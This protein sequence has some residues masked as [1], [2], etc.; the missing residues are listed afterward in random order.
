MAKRDYSSLR[1]ELLIFE[2]TYMCSLCV[3]KFSNPVRIKVC[4]HYFC[5]NC[6]QQ[7]NAKKGQCPKCKLPYAND[8][9]DFQNTARKVTEYLEKLE[10]Y[11]NDADYVNTIENEDNKEHIEQDKSTNSKLIVIEQT[12]ETKNQNKF[13]YLNKVYHLNFVDQLDKVN[14]KGESPLHIACKKKNVTGVLE[15]LKKK[16]DINKQDFAGW[17]PIVSTIIG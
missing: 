2:N 1:K 11:L 3:Q 14:A 9:I 16:I 8:E 5:E 13:I 4:G 12:E 10:E 7:R 6:L 17:A 15:L